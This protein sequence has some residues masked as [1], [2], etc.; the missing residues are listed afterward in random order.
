MTDRD[1]I[2]E[3]R[4]KLAMSSL[5]PL[6]A[7]DLGIVVE[8]QVADAAW[9][10]EN[11]ALICWLLTNAPTLLD[12]LEVAQRPPLGYVVLARR[13]ERRPDAEW[14]YRAVGSIWV[15]RA[16]A[17][18][19]ATEWQAAAEADRARYHGVDYILAEVREV[20]GCA[21]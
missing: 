2:A 6:M 13:P 7:K 17:A 10:H 19:D 4:E 9:R 18:D 20:P 14:D 5:V 21:T 12:A 15:D 3:G 11:A 1:L 8:A 16:P